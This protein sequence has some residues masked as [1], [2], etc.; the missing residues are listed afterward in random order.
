MPPPPT[1]TRPVLAG[2][3][4][5]CGAAEP[6]DGQG[7]SRG[8]FRI[9]LHLCYLGRV[10]STAV[11][12]Q[13]RDFGTCEACGQRIGWLLIKPDGR[14]RPVD[15]GPKPH[16]EY[17]LRNDGISAFNLRHPSVDLDL[18]DR[19]EGPCFWDHAKTCAVPSMKTARAVLAAGGGYRDDPERE[20]KRARLLAAGQSPWVKRY[21]SR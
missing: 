4:G 12:P 3:G 18:A 14:R 2:R 9:E 17:A 10:T 21:P 16:A 1:A 19:Q 7:L 20:R 13:L 5:T 11:V 6:G 15:P 8:P